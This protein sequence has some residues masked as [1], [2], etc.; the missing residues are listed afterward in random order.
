MRTSSAV[1]YIL[2][3]LYLISDVLC[4]VL[5]FF[6]FLWRANCPFNNFLCSKKMQFLQLCNAGEDSEPECQLF[7]FHSNKSGLCPVRRV[8]KNR[9]AS[10]F[11]F[12][13]VYI[14]YIFFPIDLFSLSP[15]P[16]SFVFTVQSNVH[17]FG[18]VFVLVF[19]IIF[20]YC[21]VL[22]LLLC[23]VWC[24]WVCVCVCVC[25]DSC[26]GLPCFFR[27]QS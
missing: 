1:V 10:L 12:V 22:F 8:R 24:V 5:Y 17:C 21:V 25:H 18:V 7:F 23:V 9:C 16:F 3:G 19:Y 2:R 13:I 11:L 26:A 4:I 27:V 15:S 20:F 6:F 14:F